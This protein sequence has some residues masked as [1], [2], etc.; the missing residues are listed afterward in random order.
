MI[1]IFVLYTDGA[2]FSKADSSFPQQ[3]E[4]EAD[5]KVHQGSPLL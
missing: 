4:S 3:E 2:C 5:N 1:D